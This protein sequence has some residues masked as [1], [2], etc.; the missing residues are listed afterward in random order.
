MTKL[1]KSSTWRHT[2]AYIQIIIILCDS[3]IRFLELYLKSTLYLFS[4]YYMNITLTCK[5][6]YNDNHISATTLRF[7]CV[8]ILKQRFQVL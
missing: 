5:L 3:N 6:C 1:R 2:F 7:K 4:Y 8:T